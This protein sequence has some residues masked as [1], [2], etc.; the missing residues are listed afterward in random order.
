MKIYRYDENWLDKLKSYDIIIDG[1]TLTQ[2]FTYDNQG[3]PIL[4]TNFKY[5]GE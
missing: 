5:K 4:I 1:N 3:N 2:N